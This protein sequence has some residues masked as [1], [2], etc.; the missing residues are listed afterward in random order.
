MRETRRIILCLFVLS[1]LLLPTA[2][3]QAAEASLY[4][5]PASGTYELGSS[6]SMSIVVNSGGGVGINASDA[7]V[8]FDPAFLRISKVSQTG[9]IF[10]LWTTEPGFSNQAGQ[11]T[12]NIDQYF[13]CF[14]LINH[15]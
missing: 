4:L 6:F 12:Y 2:R 9:S 1:L 8:V 15:N 11:I 13:I 7:V 14:N 5:S 3:V 10:N